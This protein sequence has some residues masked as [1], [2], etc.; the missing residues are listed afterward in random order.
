MSV[1]IKFCE[2]VYG[3]SAQCFYCFISLQLVGKFVIEDLE[4]E[5]DD[6]A[7]WYE[8]DCLPYKTKCRVS[9]GKC[10][11]ETCLKEIR[12]CLCFLYNL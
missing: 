7:E 11:N 4:D 10:R 5:R 2:Y 8:K 1:V 6:G 9:Y 3:Y 12:H